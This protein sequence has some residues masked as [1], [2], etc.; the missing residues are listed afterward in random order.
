MLTHVEHVEHVDTYNPLFSTQEEAYTK[1]I[2]HATEFL[3]QD[4]TN[5]VIMRLLSGDTDII[6]LSV[7][8]HLSIFFYLFRYPTSYER[9][10][11]TT[12]ELWPSG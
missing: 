11:N 4:S 7:A 9:A 3:D 8:L 5:K 6:V 10:Q 12:V 1:V 2:A